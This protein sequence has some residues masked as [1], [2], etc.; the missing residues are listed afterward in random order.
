MKRGLKNKAKIIRHT[1]ACIDRLEYYLELA[2]GTPYGD[3]NFIKEEVAIYKKY[4]NPKRKTNSYR[5]QDL[6]FI[7]R[8]MNELRIHIKIYLHDHHGLKKGNK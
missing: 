5:T 7:N 6:I 1:L 8:V 2:K 4:L 3:A